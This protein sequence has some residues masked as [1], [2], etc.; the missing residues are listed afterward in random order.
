L[1]LEK[2]VNILLATPLGTTYIDPSNRPSMAGSR[3]SSVVSPS[4]II[5][6]TLET[7]PADE[8]LQFEEHKEQLIQEA[9]AKFLANFKMDRN[10]KVVRQRT[11][12]PASL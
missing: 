6:P 1:A 5:E 8:Q 11:T 2:G 3:D 7:L 10:N 4:N 12:D 9:K